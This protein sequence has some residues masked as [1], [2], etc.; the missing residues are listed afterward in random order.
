MNKIFELLLDSYP[1]RPG[2]KLRVQTASLRE[3]NSD[4]VE[5]GDVYSLKGL[6]ACL[7]DDIAYIDELIRVN[8]IRP[9]EEY[10]SDMAYGYADAMLAQ[11]EK[12][13]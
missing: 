3:A 13:K 8:N 10:I 9:G 4:P 11:R 2:W 7:L 1:E 6:R 12:T 5:L